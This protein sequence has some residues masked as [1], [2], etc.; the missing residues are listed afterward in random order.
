MD[1]TATRT[2]TDENLR[3][4][5]ISLVHAGWDVRFILDHLK[6]K[7]YGLNRVTVREVIRDAGLNGVKREAGSARKELPIYR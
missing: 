4:E 5:I 3:A 2:R 1:D 7:Y 6:P